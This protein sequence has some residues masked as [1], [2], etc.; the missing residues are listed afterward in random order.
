M[1]PALL[2]FTG[3]AFLLSSCGERK[4]DSRSDSL[5]DA[6]HHLQSLRA[7][8]DAV[9]P[10]LMSRRLQAEME[11]LPVEKLPDLLN[12]MLLSDRVDATDSALLEHLLVRLSVHQPDLAARWIQDHAQ[13]PRLQAAVLASLSI[14]AINSPKAALDAAYKLPEAVLRQ[15]AWRS[16]AEEHPSVV[17]DAL[18]R[19]TMN[20]PGWSNEDTWRDLIHHA[21]RTKPKD[22]A[23][24]MTRQGNARELLDKWRFALL[25]NWT[26]SNAP[27]ALDWMLA[28]ANHSLL[29]FDDWLKDVTNVPVL[30]T[31]WMQEMLPKV[32]PGPHRAKLV[33]TTVR[34]LARKDTVEAERWTANLSTSADQE[35]ARRGL[36]EAAQEG[37]PNDLI[38]PSEG[39]GI[40]R[41]VEA[42][43]A[44]GLEATFTWAAKLDAPGLRH[45]ALH[46]AAR[47]WAAE[48][49]LAVE[50]AIAALTNETDRRAAEAGLKG[51]VRP[52]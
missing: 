3:L 16:V 48:N 32:P 41:Y 9:F 35:A 28:P 22:V 7:A 21:S 46:A 20:D 38:L 18:V 30:H 51:M 43:A 47:L 13:M 12:A 42:R 27:E 52:R 39:D 33:A 19:R 1:K 15:Q 25:S 4:P 49:R 11:R 10:H 6:I 17:L 23:D 36:D 5:P 45:R 8:V 29:S 34:T 31:D 2:F 26:M 50:K 37:L 44:L 24:W 14:L 40:V